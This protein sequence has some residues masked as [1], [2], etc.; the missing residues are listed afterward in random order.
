[1]QAGDIE[2]VNR[3]LKLKNQAISVLRLDAK[4]LRE[5]KILLEI[6][7]RLESEMQR[8]FDPEPSRK[9]DA[10]RVLLDD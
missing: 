6:R 8:D 2:N 1:M 10:L 3:K 4:R 9:L 7:N 5:R